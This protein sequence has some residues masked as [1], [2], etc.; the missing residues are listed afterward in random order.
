[1]GILIVYANMGVPAEYLIA[2]SIMAAPASLVISKIIYPETQVS[3]TRGNVELKVKSDY[4]NLIDAISHG[5]S[6]GFKIS[7][8]IVAML[9]G[10]IALIAFIDYILQTIS[11]SLSLDI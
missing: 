6:D 8:N 9:I 1:G 2:A 5:A 4:H 10:F 7:L 3:E 11:P